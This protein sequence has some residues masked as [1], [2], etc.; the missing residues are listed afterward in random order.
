MGWFGHNRR[1]RSQSNERS[2]ASGQQRKPLIYDKQDGEIRTQYNGKKLRIITIDQTSH[3]RR[4][5]RDEKQAVQLQ[6]RQRVLIPLGKHESFQ[7]T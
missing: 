6:V 1:T 2:A 4:V 5:P 3:G 7:K